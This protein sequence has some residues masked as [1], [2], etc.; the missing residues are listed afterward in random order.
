MANENYKPDYGV[1][2]LDTR[3]A[4][5]ART[6]PARLNRRGEDLW[7][8]MFD[9]PEFQRR[10][11]T[12]SPNEAWTLAVER[13]LERAKEEDVSPFEQ[14]LINKNNDLLTT[15]LER[16]RRALVKFIDRH[17]FFNHFRIQEV[18]RSYLFSKEGMK[19]TT[20]GSIKPQSIEEGVVAWL[21]SIDGPRFF[22]AMENNTW[23]R[24]LPDGTLLQFHLRTGLSGHFSH[25][26]QTKYTPTVSLTEVPSHQELVDFVETRIWLP[27]VRANRMKNVGSRLF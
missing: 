9:D 7:R 23:E 25:S 17:E 12:L 26:I 19:A 1:L 13:Y 21:R 15:D 6:F 27:I 24:E 11:R 3:R 14:S 10:S 5:D 16:K 2:G 20:V 22:R 8:R 18:T 4:P